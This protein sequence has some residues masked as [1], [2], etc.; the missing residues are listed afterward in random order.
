MLNQEIKTLILKEGDS[1]A[2][3]K[4]SLFG[5]LGCIFTQKKKL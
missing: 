4:A 2:V 3:V 1:K 5:T